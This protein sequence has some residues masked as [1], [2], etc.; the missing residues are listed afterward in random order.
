[1]KETS[2]DDGQ[3]PVQN[4]DD[5]IYESVP[6]IDEVTVSQEQL[7]EVLGQCGLRHRWHIDTNSY[8]VPFRWLET[9]RDKKARGIIKKFPIYVRDHLTE[10]CVIVVNEADERRYRVRLPQ[11]PK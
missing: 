3:R 7:N 4:L 2:L 10:R 1:M 5:F 11:D 9:I 6:G 8:L